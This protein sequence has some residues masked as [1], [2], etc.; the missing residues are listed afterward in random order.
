M[1]PAELVQ[2]G[3]RLYQAPTYENGRALSFQSSLPT[4]G[5]TLPA[6]SQPPNIN[7]SLQLNG[8]ATTDV[9]EGRAI[10]AV[11]NNPR[12]VSEANQNARLA[13]IN[14]T[15]ERIAAWEPL[16]TPG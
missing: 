3:G 9:L 4:L 2:A 10:R 5:G 7:L 16:T 12:A 11:Q 6:P 15:A 1:R 13:S 14:R 8:Q